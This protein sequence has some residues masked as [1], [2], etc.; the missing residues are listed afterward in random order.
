[1]SRFSNTQEVS[2]H[3]NGWLDIY[4]HPTGIDYDLVLLSHRFT[5]REGR[6][7]GDFEFIAKK[8]ASPG[9]IQQRLEH[10]WDF[11]YLCINYGISST[12]TQNPSA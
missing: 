6:N 5:F 1:M 8:A 9:D 2:L 12:P 4:G 10:V 11:T 7:T 3:W